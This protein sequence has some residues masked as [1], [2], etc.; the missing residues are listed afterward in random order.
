MKE[1][2]KEHGIV[3]RFVAAEIFAFSEHTH[4]T[5]HRLF[6]NNVMCFQSQSSYIQTL[7]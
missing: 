4:I 7:G 5:G 3:V 2:I 6:H 1:G